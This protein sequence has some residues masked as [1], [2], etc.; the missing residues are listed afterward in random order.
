[1]L[2]GDPDKRTPPE[3]GAT[4]NLDP[5][6]G[7]VNQIKWTCPRLD[8]SYNPPSW[9][10]NSNGMMAG[11]GD[12]RNK[13]EGVGFP[14]MTCDGYASPL[15]ADIHFPSCYNPDAG[16]TDYK[17][18]MAWPTENNGKKDC[19]EGYI[20]VPHLFYEAYW[21]TLKF[22]G[23][24][25]EGKGEQPFVLSNGDATGYSLHA[26]FMSGWDEELLQH[27]I[28]TCDAGAT[29]MDKCPGL[30]YGLNEEECTIE[31]PVDEQ[32]TGS[33]D[34]LPGN[35]QIT[36]WQYGGGDSSGGDSGGNSGGNSGGDNDGNGS[37]NDKTSTPVKDNN[38]PAPTTK[39]SEPP[40]YTNAP[41]QSE[42]P[43]PSV[44]PGEAIVNKPEQ[45]KSACKPRKTHTVIETITVTADAPSSPTSTGAIEKEVAGFKY[46][47]CFKDSEKRVLSGEVRPD[48]GPMSNEKCVSYCQNAGF[49][50][51]GT[52]YGGQCY[53]G[54]EIV[55]SE[56]L[57]DTSCD[58]ACEDA[59]SDVCGG[60]WALTV[61]SKDG[62]VDLKN[63][64]RRR[65]M[66]G[67]ARRHLGGHS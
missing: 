57:N 39:A 1:M 30:F 43:S 5:S 29:G 3:A 62:E 27:I 55:G 46:A 52:E 2:S 23:R 7:P 17:N 10:A 18:N 44:N 32:V 9:P 38:G 12:P 13:G 26:D 34:T 40:A 65:H 28:D 15:R 4:T 58:M 20:H 31:S 47:G 64:Q 51:A 21:D 45:G 60:G 41:V 49:A 33:F 22:A 37:G 66:H 56:R 53:C 11:M 25:E 48:L 42:E 19:P 67:H 50:V 54:N 24:W 16:L 36:G 8:N 14:D 59:A 6:N 61:Y 35:R 63:A